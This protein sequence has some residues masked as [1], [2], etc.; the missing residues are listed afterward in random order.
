MDLCVIGRGKHDVPS[1]PAEACS[2]NWQAT[3]VAAKGL[4][5]RLN[6]RMAF[7]EAVDVK[8]WNHLVY[9]PEVLVSSFVCR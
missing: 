3:V 1:A 7:L 2:T 9:Y 5:E 4:E 8:L 6:S